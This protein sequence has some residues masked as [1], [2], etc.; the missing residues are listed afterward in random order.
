LVSATRVVA[1]TLGGLLSLEYGYFET[2]QGNIAP[3]SLVI[4]AIGPP[5][6]PVTAW[7]GCEPAM[8]IVPHFYVTGV[9]AIF[10]SI[11]VII[12]AAAYI[13]NK[14]GGLVLILLSVVQLLVGG[15]FTSPFFGVL[16]SVAGTRIDAPLGWWRAHLPASVPHSLAKLWP[17][18]LVVYSV[19]FAS[20]AVLGYFFNELV[21]RLTPIVT[22]ATPIL[23]LLIALTAFAYGI[24][25]HTR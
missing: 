14:R 5:C 18:S 17:W 10:V 9:L 7:H 11:I 3:N 20:A 8:T 23:L 13:Q 6:Q 24:Q 2:L 19:W 4:N 21:L 15:R 25:R 22:V 12:W 1:S 16:A